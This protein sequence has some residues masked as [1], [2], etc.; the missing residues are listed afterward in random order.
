MRSSCESFWKNSQHCCGYEPQPPEINVPADGEEYGLWKLENLTMLSVFFCRCGVYDISFRNTSLRCSSFCWNDF[1]DVDFTDADLSLCD[2]RCSLFER[3]SFVRADLSKA[4]LRSSNFDDCDFT[5]AR[6]E[7]TK[8]TYDQGDQLPLSA[9]QRAVI[10]W[11]RTL[12]RTP[13]G[14]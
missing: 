13:L 4:D 1:I 10:V 3:V 11:R 7:G 8:L 14:G 2:M 12:G 9:A 5:D 6:M